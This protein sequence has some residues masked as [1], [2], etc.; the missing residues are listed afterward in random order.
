MPGA[1]ATSSRVQPAAGEG[2]GR[3]G[4]VWLPG[5]RRPGGGREPAV[6]RR[7]TAAEPMQGDRFTRVAVLPF[8]NLGSPG[9]QAFVAGLTE[10]VASRLAGLSSLAVPSATTVAGYDRRGKSLS[11]LGADLGVEYVIEG[12]VRWAEAAGAAAHPD[13]AQGDRVSDDTV[14]WTSSTTRRCPTSSRSRPTSRSGLPAR[15]RWH[16]TPASAAPSAARSRPSMARPTWPTSA[17]WRRISRGGPTP[18]TWRWP[19]RRWSRP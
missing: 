11:Q 6:G 12:S 2:V 1:G 10:E 3:P 13:H 18:R 5:R 14:V 17:G 9:D 16:S 4:S 15:C 7:R 19:H 8:V